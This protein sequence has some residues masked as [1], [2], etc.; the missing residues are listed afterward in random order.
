MAI[1]KCYAVTNNYYYFFFLNFRFRCLITLFNCKFCNAYHQ[2]PCSYLCSSLWPYLPDSNHSQ[3][4]YYY[5][6]CFREHIPWQVSLPQP[7]LTI[8]VVSK[9][10]ISLWPETRYFSL[11]SL[12]ASSL[13]FF[14]FRMATTQK[15][16]K[17]Q[18]LNFPH[19]TPHITAIS[20]KVL[21]FSVHFLWSEREIE[22][23]FLIDNFNFVLN[24]TEM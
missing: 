23:L 7:A 21:Q 19:I 10:L 8:E 5:I 11:S 3:Q 13:L 2:L 17:I 15:T 6:A 4:V 24:S 16:Y 14:F 9:K 22:Q 18:A 1:M 20:N 12:L